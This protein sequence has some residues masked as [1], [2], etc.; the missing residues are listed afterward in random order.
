MGK[1]PRLAVK[2][3]SDQDGKRMK[4]RNLSLFLLLFAA[5]AVTTGLTAL[6][7]PEI[8]ARIPGAEAFYTRLAE[9][10][11]RP[12]ILGQIPVLPESVAASAVPVVTWV[13]KPEATNQGRLKMVFKIDAASPLQKI[14][15]H[16]SPTVKLP[17]LPIDE[18]VV[19]VP[20]FFVGRKSLEWNGQLDVTPS[21][22][23]GTP[24]TMR[25]IAE[26]EEKQSGA[27]DIVSATL[28]ERHFTTP[29]A[30]AVYTLRK[31]LREDPENKRLDALRA[32]AGLLQ[33]REAFKNNELMLLTLRS[34][35]VR[36]ALDKSDEGLRGALDLLW[37]AAVIIEENHV[38]IAENPRPNG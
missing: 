12:D 18:D 5:L 29:L 27:S 35:A 7:I 30:Q 4:K 32:L 14:K 9:N 26:D 37:H 8:R 11:P 36:I 33:Q 23:A 20:S 13:E 31:G 10:I 1:Y 16:V 25:I 34:A 19:D 21:F 15:L 22:L 24:V 17:G 38:R 6:G 2:R 28:P 3:A